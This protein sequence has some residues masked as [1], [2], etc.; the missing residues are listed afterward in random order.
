MPAWLLV[1][2]GRRRDSW[3]SLGTSSVS[4]ALFPT[5]PQR[6]LVTNPHALRSPYL[7]V[8]RDRLAPCSRQGSPQGLCTGLSAALHILCFSLKY[9][10]G[11]WGRGAPPPSQ[12]LQNPAGT[13]TQDMEVDEGLIWQLVLAQSGPLRG[14]P[15]WHS[16]CLAGSRRTAVGESSL[17]S[18]KQGC[19][20]PRSTEAE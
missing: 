2:G 4:Q 6:L 15:T 9:C 16:P 17:C 14:L 8:C 12:D 5:A 19:G 7:T 10:W 18:C 11:A 13:S 1:L 20:N 3:L